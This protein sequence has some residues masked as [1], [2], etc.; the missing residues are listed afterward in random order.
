MQLLAH[1]I[2]TLRPRLVRAIAILWSV[3]C[4]LVEPD[5]AF[6]AVMIAVMLDLATKLVAIAA[7]Q[8]GLVP[9]IATGELSSKKAFRGTFIKLVAYFVLGVLS[10]QVQHVVQTEVAAIL[11]QTL[12]YGFLFA[13]ESI[14]ILENLIAAGLPQLKPLLA[15][16]KRVPGHEEM[17]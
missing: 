10:A 2:E 17:P 12:V 5:A 8:G 14:S 6:L 15:R 1:A 16:L 7:A 4:Y 3:F 9:A 11:S 13:V